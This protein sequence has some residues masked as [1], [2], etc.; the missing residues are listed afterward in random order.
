MKRNNVLI[1][2]SLKYYSKKIN[3]TKVELENNLLILSAEKNSISD[4]DQKHKEWG[5][6][7]IN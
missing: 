4:L 2:H 1:D 5:R 6:D 3:E 7:L